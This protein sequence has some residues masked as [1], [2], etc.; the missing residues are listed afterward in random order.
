MNLA[1]VFDRCPHL[2]WEAMIPAMLD[3]YRRV[4][5]PVLA[6]LCSQK[7]D[8]RWWHPDHSFVLHFVAKVESVALKITVF[9]RQAF[10]QV[11]KDS[12]IES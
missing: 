1:P 5:L 3:Q 10:M 9:Y 12:N 7:E 8:I 11:N 6:S 4:A 2:Q